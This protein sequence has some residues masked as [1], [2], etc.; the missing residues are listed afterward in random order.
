MGA[1]GAGG[2]AS[3]TR[4]VVVG[5][6]N[7]DVVSRV[8]RFPQPGETVAAVETAYHAGGKGANQAVASALAG[9]TV[10]MIGALG[11]DPFARILRESLQSHGVLTEAVLEKSGPSGQA[12]IT[13]DETGQNTI[14]LSVGA[15][16]L[17][18][19][20]D[21]ERCAHLI[22]RA[23]TLLVQNEVPWETT[24]AAVVLAHDAG[25]QVIV[26][27][28]PAMSLPQDVY[29]LISTLIV[30]EHEAALLSGQP[31][32]NPTEAQTAARSLLAHGV[33]E[34][35]LT[36]GE[37]GSLLAS[38][39]RE[40]VLVIPSFS[41]PVTD[42]TGAGDTFIGAYAAV[43][44]DMPAAEAL[45]VAS[46]AA[47]LAVTRPGAQEAMPTRKEIQEFLAAR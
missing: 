22:A 44:R 35:I 3:A 11:R 45:R 14:V 26:N 29:P 6:I 15:N 34:V 17:L 46:A 21:V 1:A 19:P 28:A 8:Q 23:Q 2:P 12:T 42:T 7:M 41:V 25:L 24:R 43:S 27:P 37:R 30:N 9:A 32:R 16:G 39:G 40:D 47:A 18:Q 20:V 31:V 5:S 38:T 4:I 33:A 36:L 10:T 13:L